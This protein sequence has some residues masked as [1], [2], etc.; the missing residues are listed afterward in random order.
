M[1]R[2][3]SRK[4]LL[5]RLSYTGKCLLG[6]VLDVVS[7]P[8]LLGGRF[9]ENRRFIR[10]AEKWPAEPARV[11]H[12][13]LTLAHGVR[14]V[15]RGRVTSVVGQDTW[16]CLGGVFAASHPLSSCRTLAK[17]WAKLVV[18]RCGIARYAMHASNEVLRPIR[19]RDGAAV[20]EFLSTS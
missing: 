12:A 7:L 3:L 17:E 11:Y 10:H 5:E 18:A 20:Y 14:Y 15:W 9:R 16:P 19:L 13:D 1:K 8:Y 2:A 4:N 6:P